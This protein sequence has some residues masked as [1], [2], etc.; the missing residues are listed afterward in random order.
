MKWEKVLY[1]KTNFPD[2]HTDEKQFL[3]ELRKNVNV[4]R[5]R[6]SEAV[7]GACV[8]MCQVNTIAIYVSLFELVQ[9]QQLS[10]QTL[11]VIVAAVASFC[12]AA[13]LRNDKTAFSA[14][15][16][17]EHGRTLLT[18]VLFGYGFTPVIRTLTTSIST[19]TIY[20]TSM[21]L[22]TISLV[23]HDYGMPAPV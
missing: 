15:L 19:D 20:A 18:L 4:V 17:T 9:T 2:D 1:K 5:Y 16:L 13:Y 14:A 22:F 3:S 12:F 23:F 21:L 11:L 10:S 8:V 6:L 7:C